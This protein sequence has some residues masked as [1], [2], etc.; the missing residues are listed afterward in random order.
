MFSRRLDWLVGENALAQ[1]ERAQGARP[2]LDLTL[3]NPTAAG[4]PDRGPALAA[5]LADPA[6]AR[7][8]PEPQG[9]LAARQLLAGSS[10]AG[11]PAR[12]LLTAS[13]SESYAWLFKLLC[14]PGDAVL[15]PE[16]SYPL[17]DY[18]AGLEALRV[19]RYQL[20][21][22]GD[23]QVDFSSVEAA[24]P[25]AR[26]I[27]IVNPNNPTGSFL[28]KDTLARFAALAAAHDVALIVD[29]VFADYAF[30]APCDAVPSITG[31]PDLPALAFALGGLSKGS[32]LP[33]LKL[34][35][36][37]ALGPAAL[38]DEA[39]RRLE[40]IADTYLSVGT[41]VLAALPRL[42]AIGANIRGDIQARVA[43]NR[44]HL[45]RRLTR[46]LPVSWLPAE[47]GWSA[48]L[49][50]PAL[51]GDDVWALTLLEE[52]GVVVQPGYFFDLTDLGATL[53]V[54]LLCPPAVFAEGLERI[55]ARAMAMC[56]AP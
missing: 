4:L 56:A 43:H 26:A 10:G 48:I 41:P 1:L 13:S 38:V 11:D 52:D 47:G 19:R 6:V 29:E 18:L 55:I 34:G 12:L 46:E 44:Q 20:R 25:G 32:G 33:Q 5:A 40:L 37:T 27:V 28:R 36:M 35:W 7:Y 3:S 54:S 21:F 23:W 30:A 9:P 49:R 14:D 45:G 53:V 22:A 17:F 39:L 42:L 24:L 51:H 31:T 16:P 50:V 15:V 8:R 2:L